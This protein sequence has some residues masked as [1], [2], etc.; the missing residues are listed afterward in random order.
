MN[1]ASLSPSMGR[2][3]GGWS[4]SHPPSPVVFPGEQSKDK[5]QKEG[6]KVPGRPAIH[7]DRANR[8]GSWEI[9]TRPEAAKAKED[10][11]TRHGVISGD[12]GPAGHPAGGLQDIDDGLICC[13]SLLQ[14]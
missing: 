5:Q 2:G 9:R 14:G 7:S 6:E 11:A 13:A 1:E 10:E 3:A 4:P 8:S 12:W